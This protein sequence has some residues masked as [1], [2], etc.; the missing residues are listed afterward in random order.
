MGSRLVPHH[1]GRLTVLLAVSCVFVTGLL[2]ARYLGESEGGWLD[3]HAY[4]AI[5]KV[6]A[7]QEWLLHVMATPSEPIPVA[8]MVTTVAVVAAVRRRPG[9]VALIIV[10]PVAAVV[11]ASVILKP[12]FG[13]THGG[14]LVFPSGHTASLV[15]VLT[16]LTLLAVATSNRRR[17]A[18]MVAVA[19][20]GSLVLTV[21]LVTA[22]VGLRYHYFTDTVGGFCSA[23]AT[24]LVV[25][26]LIDRIGVRPVIG[27][28]VKDEL[29]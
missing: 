9:V 25:A 12:L 18:I 29:K 17:R 22:L 5:G 7:G 8:L 14:G 1:L 20:A 27:P 21:A 19:L 15:S 13:R 3:Q 24:V 16:V 2:G 10:G 28:G 11:L 4:L 26:H 6:F 23:V